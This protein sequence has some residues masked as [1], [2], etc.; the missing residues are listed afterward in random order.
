M[1]SHFLNHVHFSNC[2]CWILHGWTHDLLKRLNYEMKEIRLLFCNY[3]D[4]Y[5]WHN[6][7]EPQNKFLYFSNGFLIC[8]KVCCL[9]FRSLLYLTRRV[10]ILSTILPCWL[11]P[12]FSLSASW[13]TESCP[14]TST[15]LASRWDNLYLTN[16]LMFTY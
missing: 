15:V 8:Q 2:N 12:S 16:R 4:E 11:F 7:L 3:P 10:I 13:S 6:C 5:S 9:V 14:P 1:N